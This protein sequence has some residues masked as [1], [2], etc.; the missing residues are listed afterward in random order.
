MKNPFDDYLDLLDQIR[1]SLEQL[2]VLAKEKSNTVRNNDLLHLDEIM[3]Q[4]QAVALTF[5]GLEQRQNTLLNALGLKGVPLSALA[6]QFPP[7]MRLYARQRI[8]KLQTQYKVYQTCS[9]VARNTLEC[10]LHLIEK[11]LAGA[12]APADNGPGYQSREPEIPSAMK[13]DFRA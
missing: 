11:V 6:D 8:E 9:E 13:T 7:K 12:S 2:S 4:E 5:R 10:N 3:K 1:A